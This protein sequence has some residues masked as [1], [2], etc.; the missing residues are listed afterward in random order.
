[1]FRIG[2]IKG[3]FIFFVTLI[4]I[5]SLITVSATSYFI[6]YNLMLKIY[7]SKATEASQKYSNE[8]DEWLS[9]QSSKLHSIKEDIEIT[10]DYSQA[11]LSEYFTDKV[12]N[13]NGEVLDYYMG[14]SDKQMADGS[15]WVP[16]AD[17]DCTSREWYKDAVSANKVIFTEPYID[18][19]SKKMVITIAEPVHKSG[20]VVGVM[21][22]DITI[23]NLVK[24]VNDI[25]IENNSYGFLIDS[26]N[27]FMT[28][29]NKDFLPTDKEIF[30]LDKVLNGK[31][32]TLVEKI[33]TNDSSVVELKDYDGENK[34]FILSKINI[35]N[36]TL[37]FAIPKTE[38]IKNLNPLLIGFVV[39]IAILIL[40]VILVVPFII[41]GLYKPIE[42]LKRIASGDFRDTITQN[43]N[44]KTQKRNFKNEFEEIAYAADTVKKQFRDTI[45][46]TKNETESVRKSVNI[47]IHNVENLNA[48]I[49]QIVTVIS[50]FSNDAQETASSAQEVNSITH[51]INSTVENIA[52]K[53]KSA[54]V[55]SQKIIKKAAKIKKETTESQSN[56][57]S[58]YMATKDNLSKAIEES[59]EVEQINMLSE[60][61]LQIT[62]QTNLLALNAS[63]EAARAG[64]AGKGFAVVAEEIRKLAEDSKTTVDAIQNVTTKVIA[65]VENLSGSSSRLLDFVEKQI[66]NDYKFM[67]DTAN[68]YKDDAENYNDIAE[69]L[70]ETSGQL[71]NAIHVISEAIN[72]ISIS[73][74]RAASNIQSITEETK[75]IS[76]KSDKVLDV[77]NEVNSSCEKLTELI[78][79]FKI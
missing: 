72:E 15:G 74:N 78:S 38:I 13:T 6:S 9:I 53:A 56:V 8:I 31:F 27:G 28:H 22:A 54:S 17:F 48:N 24:L 63:I 42:Q 71:T 3:R 30:Y 57:Q 45:I 37:G 67:L 76:E 1:M 18:A 25:K 59:K 61:I 46:G 16:P 77:T 36:W 65:S 14:Y 47:A 79:T 73:N 55:S 58:M 10:G 51:Q 23:D 49:D 70:R 12:D 26:N 44:T 75:V 5:I 41:G 39:V 35:S 60:S 20:E 68:S 50:T 2:T 33:D 32:E 29:E 21:A 62:S 52:V 66:I 40:A 11:R 4:C 34:Y 43:E 7:E 19:D 69:Y 64:E